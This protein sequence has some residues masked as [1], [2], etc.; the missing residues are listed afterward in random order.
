MSVTM[1][2]TAIVRENLSINHLF[3][4]A[5]FS[6]HVGE[7][8]RENVAKEFGDWFDDI[9]F[10][11]MACAMNATSALEAYANERFA[12]GVASFPNIQPEV[13]EKFWELSERKSALEKFDLILT[14]R[15]EPPINHEDKIH[16]NA[17]VL[18]RLRNALV[19][20]KPEWSN[21]KKKHF[22]L[23]ETLTQT[24]G[25]ASRHA[26][27]KMFPY[28][29]MVHANTQWC[30]HTVIEFLTHFEKQAKLESFKAYAP[31]DARLKA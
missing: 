25:S 26:F 10:Y 24:M 6:R 14:L 28:K 9:I 21:E 13:I 31:T 17:K 29:W 8:E 4:A 5:K 18:V 12:D 11:S 16:R 3:A 20:F 1:T 23:S 7:I 27:A 19:H 30:V 15:Q 2:A 22:E